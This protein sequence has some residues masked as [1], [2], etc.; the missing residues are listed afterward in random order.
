MNKIAIFTIVSNNYF[1]RALTLIDSIK[2]YNI[3]SDNYIELLIVAT[4][5]KLALMYP[6]LDEAQ[7][8]RLQTEVSVLVDNIKTPNA[9]DRMIIREDYWRRQR[10]MSQYELMSGDWLFR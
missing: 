5:H 4:A 9:A 10:R 8:N 7:M 3:E 1:S 2:E 6:R